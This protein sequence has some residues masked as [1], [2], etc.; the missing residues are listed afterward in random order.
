M[1][2]VH[3]EN[4]RQKCIQTQLN[5]WMD[6]KEDINHVLSIDELDTSFGITFGTR[7]LW[8]IYYKSINLT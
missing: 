6:G 1:K 5:N 7:K 3:S 8:K 2:M 4:H